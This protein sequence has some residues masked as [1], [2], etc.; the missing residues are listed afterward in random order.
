MF[1]IMNVHMNVYG[2]CVHSNYL[3]MS[4]ISCEDGGKYIIG[5]RDRM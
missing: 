1:V 4:F 2:N 5:G 3:C